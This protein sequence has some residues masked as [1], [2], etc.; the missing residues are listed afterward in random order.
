[1]TT[2][3]AVQAAMRA[4]LEAG[5]TAAPLRFKNEPAPLPDEP[6]PFVYVELAVED[7]DFIAFGGGRGGNLQRTT[8]RIEAHVLV[9]V[10][11]GVAS[12]L[13]WAEAI[14]ALF[15]GRRIDGVS[16]GSA[17]A[18]PGAGRSDDGN[19]DLAAIVEIDLF[20]DKTG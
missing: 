16:Y 20:F 4:T 2:V 11:T 5:F 6:A 18:L 14:A 7:H 1:M 3:A 17:E 15:R 8:G 19:Y 12:G 13:L 9:P 10:G